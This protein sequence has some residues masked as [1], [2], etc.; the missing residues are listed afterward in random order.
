MENKVKVCKTCGI[1]KPVSEYY[2][3][4]GVPNGTCKTCH[5]ARSKA[6]AQKRRDAGKAVG[7]TPTNLFAIDVEAHREKRATDCSHSFRL[8]GH[9]SIVG[10]WPD[11]YANR[12][13]PEKGK[14]HQ[15]CIECGDVKTVTVYVPEYIP[16]GGFSQKHVPQYT[17]GFVPEP[18][19]AVPVEWLG[20][21]PGDE[22]PEIGSTGEAEAEYQARVDE[23][24]RPLVGPAIDTP[25]EPVEAPL[26]EAETDTPSIENSWLRDM[27]QL[28]EEVAALTK[29]LDE[30]RAKETP[31]IEGGVSQ[32]PITRWEYLSADAVGMKQVALDGARL[33]IERLRQEVA[34]LTKAVEHERAKVRVLEIRYDIERLLEERDD[35]ADQY[36]LP[37]PWLHS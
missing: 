35:L 31:T 4:R 32:G 21:D 30:E 24:L 20:S 12:P 25:G 8:C 2:E 19:S 33:E 23:R 37:T 5:N 18:S 7:Q 34:L 16:A 1:E 28:R 15:V 9:T 26:V 14:E 22:A 6:H 17:N 11:Y 36:G 10:R 29:A 27:E 13:E 3:S